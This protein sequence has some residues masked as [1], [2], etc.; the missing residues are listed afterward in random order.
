MRGPA[1][2]DWRCS[3]MSAPHC[4][5]P[6]IRISM[7]ILT[8][9]AP[10][11][12]CR[13][14]PRNRFARIAQAANPTSSA[15]AGVAGNCSCR[16][17]TGGEKSCAAISMGADRRHPARRRVD[18][19]DRVQRDA[20]VATNARGGRPHQPDAGARIPGADGR[21]GICI[22]GSGDRHDVAEH[23]DFVLIRTRGGLSGWVARANLG[24]VVPQARDS[25]DSAALNGR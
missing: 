5:R 10:P 21:H 2:R 7:P 6:M 14:R 11:H 20:A 3:T 24:A 4:W 8:T 12:M 19:P 1:S 25:L 18:C 13:L 9:F 15:W 23:E 22:A 16:V 17:R